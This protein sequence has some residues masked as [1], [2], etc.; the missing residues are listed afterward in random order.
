MP[1]IYPGTKLCEISASGHTILSSYNLNFDQLRG[2]V[3]QRN[4]KQSQFYCRPH[5][6]TTLDRWLLLFTT[7]WAWVLSYLLR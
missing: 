6:P 4:I 7:I 2:A 1:E 3:E 5:M